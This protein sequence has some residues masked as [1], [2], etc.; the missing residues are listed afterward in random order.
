MATIPDNFEDIDGSGSIEPD[1]QWAAYTLLAEQELQA[2]R[3]TQDE[4]YIFIANRVRY[5]HESIP[6]GTSLEEL[7]LTTYAPID[8]DLITSPPYTI[9]PS[10]SSPAFPEGSTP[11]PTDPNAYY[12]SYGNL[13]LLP[14]PAPVETEI[15][16]SD[17]FA[18][19]QIG[20]GDVIELI[21]SSQ[22]IGPDGNPYSTEEYQSWF[23]IDNEYFAPGD[24]ELIPI[25]TTF[26]ETY[27]V[28]PISNPHVMLRAIQG[29]TDSSPYTVIFR[30]VG[31]DKRNY[32]NVLSIECDTGYLLTQV[33]SANWVDGNNEISYQSNESLQSKLESEKIQ[34][35]NG[36]NSNGT[37]YIEP[38][39]YS[40]IK[41]VGTEPAVLRVRDD[42]PETDAMAKV[43]PKNSDYY[44]NELSA[45]LS[46]I[47]I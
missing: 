33:E 44:T 3:I 19:P 31:R 24:L 46:L 11:H 35:S 45:G 18:A 14:A 39:Y 16:I 41:W 40:D 29:Y 2:Q 25:N 1:E 28:Y 20:S 26:G 30:N 12:D 37:A 36:Q 23:L 6:E 32:T 5:Y 17:A 38:Y 22:I 47:H 27:E 13:V 9:T 10:A 8:P 43:L 7:C 4:F 15:T 34:V 21:H 42:Y